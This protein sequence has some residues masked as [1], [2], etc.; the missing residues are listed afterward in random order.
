VFLRWG[1]FGILA[2]A[3]LVY[4]YNASKRL[5][6]SRQPQESG[7]QVQSARPDVASEPPS[8]DDAASNKLGEEIPGHCDTELQ[9]A[10]RALQ[11]KRSGEPL[12]R[13][14]RAQII[15]FESDPL[16]RQRLEEVART[17][18]AW[19]GAEPDPDSMRSRV[20]DQCRQLTPAS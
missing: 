16:R 10:A 20:V 14:L 2:V 11:A 5:A 13:V 6:D 18:Y 19:E 15:A 7:S 9:V 12:D 1:V 8:A 4:A 3:A 17:W